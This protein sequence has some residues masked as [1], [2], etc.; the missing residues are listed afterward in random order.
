MNAPG[1]SCLCSIL[2]PAPITLDCWLK[3]S[4]NS[5]NLQRK[6]LSWRS[7]VTCLKALGNQ[8]ASL[9]SVHAVSTE[10][11]HL[12][13]SEH[14][15]HIHLKCLCGINIK[16]LCG[17][18]KWP[19]NFLSLNSSPPFS[20][21]NNCCICTEA[22]NKKQST[23]NYPKS[24][25]IF[26]HLQV[27]KN[28]YLFSWNYPVAGTSETCMTPAVI[29]RCCHKQNACSHEQLRLFRHQCLV[30]SSWVER[31]ILVFRVLNE[32]VSSWE[33]TKSEILRM[34]TFY[35]NISFLY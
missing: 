20:C 13:S 27:S 5:A 22:E 17:L 16:L 1:K 11:L 19:C 28:I 8:S 12:G 10:I 35:K 6:L 24:V 18:V 7:E 26:A 30:L 15:I 4:L 2:R 29:L 14:C 32:M 33:K 9:P 34:S 31:V 25:K 21:I 23:L 3:F